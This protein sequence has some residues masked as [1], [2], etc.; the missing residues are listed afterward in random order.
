MWNDEIF[1]TSDMPLAAYL[2]CRGFNL[3]GI[4]DDEANPKRKIFQYE[5]R[6]GI[7]VEQIADEFEAGKLKVEPK[8]YFYRIR[9]VKIKIND[10]VKSEGGSKRPVSSW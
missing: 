6:A 2:L 10:Y 8:D 3:I 9:E 1:E 5:R 7:D 4:V